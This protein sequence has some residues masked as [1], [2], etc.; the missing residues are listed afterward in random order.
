MMRRALLLSVLLLSVP[1]IA[2]CAAPPAPD[3]GAVE[4]KPAPDWQA[5]AMVAAANPLAVEAGLA[6]LRQGGSAVDAAIAVQ[7]VLGLVEPQ[8][9]GL[10]GGAFLIHYDAASGDVAAYDGRETAPAGARPDM[11]LTASGEPEAFLAAVQSGDAVGVPG[12]VALLAAAHRDHGRLSLAADLGPAIRLAEEGFAV[13]PR[14][15]RVIAAVAGFGPLLPDAAAYLTTDGTTPLPAGHILKNPAYGETLKRIAAEGPRG[16]YE[17]PVA[18]AMVAAV[19]RGNAPGTLTAEDLKGFEARRLEP[20]CRPYRAVLVCGMGPPSSGGIAVLAALGMLGQ[21]DLSGG[22]GDARAWHLLIEAERL[23]YADRD[24]YAAD[25]RFVAVPVAGLIDADY[26]AGRAALIAPDR[27]MAEAQAGTPPGA[28]QRAADLSG[29][30]TGTSHFVVVD[31]S[32]NV[33]SM[34]TTIEGPFGSQRMAA[35]FFLNNQMTDFSFRPADEKGRPIA[36]AVA[37]GKKPR[38]SMAPTIVFRDGRFLLAAGSPGGNAIIGYVLKTLVG[39]LDWGLTPQQAIALPNVVA[40]GKPVVEAGFD[41]GL[42]AALSAMGHE[43]SE[44]RAGEASGL[45]AVMLGAD[46]RLAGGADPRREGIVASP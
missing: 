37:P 27:A 44:A 9:S 1:L 39:V 7:A 6:V 36:N 32:G 2:G 21:F 3:M 4:A 11:F 17:G 24:L 15:S 22:T 23:A 29:R 28:P 26:L 8:S 25:D 18:A 10:G 46:G 33:V 31:A 19:R 30:W 13:S 12:L 42:R 43:I 14:L 45:H 20:L 16:F 38:S 5:G 41:G 35:G 40:R 34:T